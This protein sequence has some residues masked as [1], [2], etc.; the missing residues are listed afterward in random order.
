MPL[1]SAGVWFDSADDRHPA[2]ARPRAHRPS[3]Q[4]AADAPNFYL[5]MPDLPGI[6]ILVAPR[7]LPVPAVRHPIYRPR[8]VQD[9]PL[10]TNWEQTVAFL[11]WAQPT[12]DRVRYGHA[13]RRVEPT[14]RPM[15]DEVGIAEDAQLATWDVPN[16]PVIRREPRRPRQQSTVDPGLQPVLGWHLVIDQAGVRHWP[17]PRARRPSTDFDPFPVLV[18]VELAWIGK[19]NRHWP[20]AP[21]RRAAE[22]EQPGVMVGPQ[23]FDSITVIAED[24]PPFRRQLRP[25]RHADN[26]TGTLA[27][28][29]KT[30][31]GPF[32]AIEMDVF[33]AGFEQG[34][35]R[36]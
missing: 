21:A 1:E 4:P 9:P 16:Q 28:G 23:A 14:V 34:D 35:I 30:I 36:P 12:P 7:D 13:W 11:E 15:V 29:S 3:L 10:A 5:I 2:F 6:D 17:G 27:T 33:C 20:A 25:R 24:S 26:F 18:D 19:D 31:T 8:A 22:A 32:W